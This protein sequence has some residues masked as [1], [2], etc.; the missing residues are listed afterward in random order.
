MQERPSLYQGAFTSP[1]HQGERMRLRGRPDRRWVVVVAA[2][3]LIA[4]LAVF[5]YVY[6]IQPI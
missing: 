5:A 1:A 4:I 3:V 6:Y 2:I